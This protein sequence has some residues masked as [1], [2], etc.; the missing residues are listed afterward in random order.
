M[1]LEIPLAEPRG[2]ATKRPKNRVFAEAEATFPGS[3]LALVSV[4]L[5]RST[6]NGPNEMGPESPFGSSQ[7][8][9]SGAR[10]FLLYDT[11][12]GEGFNL[13]REATGKVGFYCRLRSHRVV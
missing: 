2:Q 3:E 1:P 10:R 9:G 7:L 12:Y 11:K 5:P 8:S 4:Q 6:K 13:Q